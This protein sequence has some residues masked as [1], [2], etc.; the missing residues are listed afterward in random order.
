MYMENAAS[1]LSHSIEETSKIAT[2]FAKAIIASPKFKS[3]QHIK[4]GLIGE[5][6]TGKSSISEAL[7]QQLPPRKKLSEDQFGQFSYKTQKGES[8]KRIDTMAMKVLSEDFQAIAQSKKRKQVLLIE[9]ADLATNN[10]AYDIIATIKFTDK[11]AG[12]D[13]EEKIEQ[14]YRQDLYIGN[15]RDKRLKVVNVNPREIEIST[16]NSD[17]FH[18]RTFEK[19]LC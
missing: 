3:G 4:I 19:N 11:G 12:I 15:I 8:V 14:L 6:D 17:A 5:R 2:A 13:L 16:N 10:V 9:H 1:L 7:T 18:Q